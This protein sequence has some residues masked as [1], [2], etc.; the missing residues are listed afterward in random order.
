MSGLNSFRNWKIGFVQQSLKL[1]FFCVKLK[2]E[3]D[4]I[5]I[6]GLAPEMQKKPYKALRLTYLVFKLLFLRKFRPGLI[7]QF[8]L[9]KL[10]LCGGKIDWKLTGYQI[11]ISLSR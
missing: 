2:S 11:L 6:W 1:K 3:N 9:H 5:C 7:H 4:G 8:L 10:L